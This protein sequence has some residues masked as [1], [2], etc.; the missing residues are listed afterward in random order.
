MQKAIAI[1]GKLMMT[2]MMTMTMMMTMMNTTISTAPCAS[3]RRVQVTTALNF[4][5]NYEAWTDCFGPL[6]VLDVPV[7][8]LYYPVIAC[9]VLYCIVLHLVIYKAILSA[10]AFQKRFQCEQL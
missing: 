2:T 8:Y 4:L 10:R 7:A 6:S 5:V 1:K 9:I 3:P